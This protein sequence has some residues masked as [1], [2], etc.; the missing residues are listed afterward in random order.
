MAEAQDMAHPHP[1][2]DPADELNCLFDGRVSDPFCALIVG[3]ETRGAVIMLAQYMKAL[4]LARE[5]DDMLTKHAAYLAPGRGL[6]AAPTSPK[7]RRM[8]RDSNSSF[9]LEAAW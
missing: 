5:I 1:A 6:P 9:L 2:C 7:M 4:A 8:L 3:G